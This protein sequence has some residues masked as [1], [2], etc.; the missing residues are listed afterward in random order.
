MD[1]R[2]LLK[3]LAGIP[4]L[5]ALG[6]SAWIRDDYLSEQGS[7]LKNI[8]N[9]NA[10]APPVTG[11]MA[12]DPIRIGIIGP[13]GRGID[14]M[15]STG[16]PPERV[17]Q[18]KNSKDPR[19]QAQW[20][21]FKAQE[22]LNVRYTAICDI[23][24][25]RIEEALKTVD[26]GE[27]K[28]KPE[29]YR[30]YEDLL[31][32]P[33]VDAVIIATSDHW[34]APIAIDA[35]RAGKHVY[36]E[37][38]MTHKVGETFAL[39]EAVLQNPEVVFQVG[40]QHRQTQ[41]FL[42]AQDIINKEIL[43]HVNLVQASSNRNSDGGAWQYDL[44]ADLYSPS[45]VDWDQF[46]G[47]APKIPFNLEHYRRWRKWW[48]YGTGLS[49]D[50]LTHDYDRINCVL[51]VGIPKTV[52][53]SG[54]IYTHRDGR[55]VPDVMQIVME[56]PDYFRGS[57]QEKGKEKGLTFLWSASQGNSFNRPTVL[58]GHDATM[59]LGNT[60]TL[61]A[62]ANSTRYKDHLTE[63]IL[64]A[65]KPVY[66]YDPAASKGDLDGISSATSKYFEEKG[67]L[68]TYR[69]GKK[70]DSTYLHVR[71]WLSC[72]R[73]GKKPSCGIKEGFEEAIAA[74]MASLSFKTGK[75]AEWDAVNRRI[76]L[77]GEA[78]P[79]SELDRIITSEIQEM[80]FA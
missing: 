76:L 12:G 70:V 57:S 59:E 55:T 68:Y 9:I 28:E 63:G 23:A 43:G 42:T 13:G 77:A 47:N 74:H 73:H 61:Y 75:E 48:S 66:K 71:E 49:G 3:S 65:G 10:V 62:D 7:E 51:K 20:A 19:E 16:Y 40:H 53:A 36:V 6:L 45:T 41:S 26:N 31:N 29:V 52:M 72:I 24:D 30:R 79:V 25:A 60:L 44:H 78:V 56:F 21:A 15:R 67:L 54:G 64:D 46:L 58:M 38:C 2:E 35:L 22:N 50:L 69:D 37:K 18:W 34:H 1:R 80:Q 5:G 14:L 4:V 32:N 39:E 33:N 27:Q 17:F 8:L 11:S